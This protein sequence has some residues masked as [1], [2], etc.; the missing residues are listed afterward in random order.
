MSMVSMGYLWN[1]YGL[2]ILVQDIVTCK[3][4]KEFRYQEFGIRLLF[5]EQLIVLAF[6]NWLNDSTTKH[7]PHLN[8]IPFFPQT[9]SNATKFY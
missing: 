3:T 6:W 9:F 4:K 1:I 8:L 7:F 5:E 2:S